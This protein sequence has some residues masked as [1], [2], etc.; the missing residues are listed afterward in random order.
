MRIAPNSHASHEIRCRNVIV[1]TV[2]YLAKR[3][4]E[5]LHFLRFRHAACDWRREGYVIR[6]ASAD[7]AVRGSVRKECQP[8]L[9]FAAITSSASRQFA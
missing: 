3:A 8:S 6:F 1:L 2:D 9:L 5:R 4:E 7:R